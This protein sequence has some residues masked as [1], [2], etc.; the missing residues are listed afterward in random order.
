M[1]MKICVY[2][3]LHTLSSAV[4][5]GTLAAFAAHAMLGFLGSSQAIPYLTITL[6]GV[7][8]AVIACALWPLVA[9]LVAEH[10]LGTAY[11]M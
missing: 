6:R 11:G 10:Q 3:S 4:S 1:G 9:H 5:A 8:F 7:T 2:P